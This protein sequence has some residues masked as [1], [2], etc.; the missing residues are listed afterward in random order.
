MQFVHQPLTW[1]FFLVLVP[2]LIHLINMMRHR[3]VKWAAMDFLLQSYKK[4]R[5]WI[6]LKQLLLLLM[7]MAAVALAVAMLAQWVSRGQWLDLLGGKPTHHY[8]LLDDSYSMSDRLGGA[9][10]F[11]SGL[12]AIQRIGARTAVAAQSGTQKFTLIRFSRAAR[13]SAELE[14]GVDYDQVLDFNAQIVDTEFDVA[15]EAKRNSFQVTELASGPGPALLLVKE[16]IGLASSES[17]QVYV[18]SDFRTNQWENP[19]ELRGLLQEI[20]RSP[21]EIHLV[22]CVREARQNLAVVDVTPANETRAAGVPLFVNATVKNFG[23]DTA[24]NVQLKVRTD[25]YDPQSQQTASPEQLRPKI[26]ELPTVLINEIPAGQSV[27]RSVQVFFPKPGQHVVDATL[28]DDPVAVDN[29]RWCV[30][31]FPEG[32]PVLLVDGS[33]QQLHAFFLQSVFEPGGRANT[34]VRPE[35]NTPAYLRDTLPEILQKYRAIYLLDVPRLDDRAVENLEA[36][37]RGGGGLGVFV[38]PEVNIAFYAKQLYREGLGLMPLPL[39]REDELPLEE[40]ENVPDIEPAEHPVFSVFLGE[41]NPFIRQI[42][43]ERFLRPPTDWKPAPDSSVQIAAWLRNRTPL[44]VERKF[45][46][47]RVVVFLTT[48]APTWNNW[49]N[50]PSFVVMVLK[51]Q[52]YLAASRRA[53]EQRPVGSPVSVALEANKYRQDVTFVTPGETPETRTVVER[54]AARA[55]PNSPV[56][57]AGIGNGAAGSAANGGGDTDHSGIYE[58][59]PVT[60]AGEADVRR[61]ALN[62]E[63]SEGDL[64]L[65]AGKPLLDKL[66][67]VKADYKYAEEYEYEI[68]RL[69][70]N[71]RSLLLM[72]ILI[73]LLF[74]EQIMGYWA[75]YHPP[76]AAAVGK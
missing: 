32:E 54:V 49:G 41:R 24:R 69:G 4:H 74:A 20:Q 13:V 17:R 71:N 55:E 21:A 59:W 46:E 15:L 38:G 37:V 14:Q 66:D 31:D 22:G 23:P 75:S 65:L 53:V 50:D 12:A 7:R 5:K 72:A 62:V 28:Q 63:P 42:T 33:Q 9:S 3:R 25:F 26:D 56:L 61:Q 67:P 8:V 47:G 18:V 73:G 44:A 40:D 43:V 48:A 70:G 10:A 27:T 36:Y 6:W 19:A 30:M 29:R 51:L 57:V 45:G 68:A 58:A 11:E 2:L 52:S 35:I 39:L 76:R 1:G 64:A 60:I 34:G 16:L